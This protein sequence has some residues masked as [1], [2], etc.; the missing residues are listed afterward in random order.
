MKNYLIAVSFLTLFNISHHQCQN[1]MSNS[2]L[3]NHNTDKHTYNSKNIIK[4]YKDELLF[5]DSSCVYLESIDTAVISY[6]DRGFKLNKSKSKELKIYEDIID[7]FDLEKDDQY[8]YETPELFFAN[9][10][11]KNFI[12]G[13]RESNDRF[14]KV[15]TFN[16]SELESYK[17]EVIKRE[18]PTNP[19]KIVELRQPTNLSE[20]CKEFLRKYPDADFVILNNGLD[21]TRGTF[22][23]Y[24]PP[25]PPNSKKRACAIR[26][27]RTIIDLNTAKIQAYFLDEDNLFYDSPLVPIKDG[28]IDEFENIGESFISIF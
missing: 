27:P 14:L 6:Y 4:F 20:F 21:I 23:G 15:M 25:F 19:K 11:N 17:V 16:R 8:N 13:F 26:I 2:T 12:N 5:T 18:L 22:D 9:E 3:L 24:N 1:V 7:W 28:I 10:F